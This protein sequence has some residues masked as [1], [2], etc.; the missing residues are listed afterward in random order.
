[1]P[2]AGLEPAIPAIQRPQ[3]YAL[4]RTAFG[5]GY[6]IISHKMKVDGMAAACDTPGGEEKCIQNFSG[7]T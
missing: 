2:S 4:D 5:V 6:I 7:E 1:M 3:T